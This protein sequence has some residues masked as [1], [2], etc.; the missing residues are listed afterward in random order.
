MIDE[1]K[2]LLDN[3]VSWLK[4]KTTLRQINDWVEIT[5]PFLDRHND[6]LQI[7]AKGENSGYIL[8]DDGYIIEDLEQTGCKLDTQK[9]QSLLKMTLN[10]FGVKLI[11]KRLEIHASPENFALRKHNLVQAMLAVN[12]L[13]YMAEPFVSTMFFEDV[14]SWLDLNQ[15][16][17]TPQVKFTGK[18]GYDHL[19]DFVIPKSTLKPERIIKAINHPSKET[20]EA[21]VFACLDTREIRPSESLAY[22]LLND[23]DHPVPNDVI[24]ALKNYE[25][26]PIPW[27]TRDS[28]RLDLA[29]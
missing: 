21:L 26:N 3:Y 1:I 9:R 13:F 29:S 19:F 17:Y 22:A 24:S 5:T 4:E 25:V 8:S 16:R 23:T 15:I 10:G 11:D 2:K 7:Y 14:V 12:D 6:Q 27:S 28:V 20:A 18:T